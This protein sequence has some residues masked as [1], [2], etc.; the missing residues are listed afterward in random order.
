MQQKERKQ[1]VLLFLLLA[2]LSFLCENL[3]QMMFPLN[4]EIVYEVS[5]ET[6]NPKVLSSYERR[7]KADDAGLNAAVTAKLRNRRLIQVTTPAEEWKAIV[8]LELLEAGAG[9]IL[10][11]VVRLDMGA[12]TGSGCV[13][14]IEEDRV[15]ISTCGHVLLEE[16]QGEVTFYNGFTATGYVLAKS[17]YFDIGFLEIPLE[18]ISYELRE[19]FRFLSLEEEAWGRL[20]NGERFYAVGSVEVPAGDFYE[21]ILDDKEV[22]VPEFDCYMFAGSCPAK[23]GMSGGGVFDKDGY[24]IGIINGGA[25]SGLIVG[26]S[27]PVVLGQYENL[28][29]NQGRRN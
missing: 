28:V 3:A 19:S 29:L 18:N 17:D 2:I 13:L 26:L 20:Q 8:N 11:G 24:L 10:A 25:Q 4:E 15:V 22:Y 21:G 14:A 5:E 6:T 12:V 27:L 1:W 23:A 9:E 7:L 16:R